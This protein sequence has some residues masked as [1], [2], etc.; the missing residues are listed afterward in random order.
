MKTEKL[1]IKAKE[2]EMA[3]SGEIGAWQSRDTHMEIGED[4]RFY[5]MKNKKLKNSI[6]RIHL[7]LLL[8]GLHKEIQKYLVL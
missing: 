2:M 3:E 8:Y 6:D 5:M 4:N 7:Y 1:Q